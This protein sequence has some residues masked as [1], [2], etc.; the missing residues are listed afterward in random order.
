MGGHKFGAVL[1]VILH[2]GLQFS[3]AD[4]ARVTLACS[5]A[6]A[7]FVDR[8]GTLCTADAGDVEAMLAALVDRGT[9]GLGPLWASIDV[10]VLGAVHHTHASRLATAVRSVSAEGLVVDLTALQEG[11][12][13]VAADTVSVKAYKQHAPASA[14]LR[15]TFYDSL[16]AGAFGSAPAIVWEERVDMPELL[17]HVQA[18]S[19]A[20]ASGARFYELL[21]TCEYAL[22]SLDDAALMLPFRQM[23]DHPLRPTVQE[24]EVRIPRRW[25]RAIIA[26]GLR[27]ALAGRVG[28]IRC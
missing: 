2:N 22:E 6:R 10:R 16:A 13:P 28:S 12:Q 4:V 27:V 23:I 1:R 26:R 24:M 15:R 3:C 8:G 18:F 9:R 5:D 7:A 14:V 21:A 19:D 11:A 17:E 20:G 25:D